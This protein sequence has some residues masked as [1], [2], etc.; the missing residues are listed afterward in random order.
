MM[1]HTLRQQ[2]YYIKIHLYTI[3]LITA[4]MGNNMLS[5]SSVYASHIVVTMK[6]NAYAKIS[7]LSK[8][9]KTQQINAKIFK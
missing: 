2:N 9:P 8:L 4:T 5:I 6:E 3:K 7:E 1:F